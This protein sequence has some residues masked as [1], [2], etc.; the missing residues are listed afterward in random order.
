[1]RRPYYRTLWT[2]VQLQ[3]HERIEEIAER[4]RM[5]HMAGLLAIAFHE[6]KKLADEHHRLLKD[7]GMLPT[8]DEAIENVQ[9]VIA[10]MRQRALTSG[11]A[12]E[13]NDGR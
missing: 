12:S 13:G 9:D 2:W 7:S 8:P 3:E 5:L 10:M 11:E 1:M 6:P 4:S